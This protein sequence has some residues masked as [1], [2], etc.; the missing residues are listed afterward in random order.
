MKN[1]INIEKK[2]RNKD[3]KFGAALDYIPVVVRQHGVDEPCLLTMAA[4][5]KGRHEWRN[6]LSGGRA[7]GVYATEPSTFKLLELA[8]S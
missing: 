3:R 7:H 2:V 4:I 6:S 5:N 8:V 1:L